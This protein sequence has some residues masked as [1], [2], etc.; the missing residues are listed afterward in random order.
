MA[1]GS[2]V[3]P[4]LNPNTSPNDESDNDDDDNEAF[5]HDIGIVYASL[6]G[7]DNAHA[8]VKHLMET[9]FEHKETIKD[10]NS[11]V[12]EGKWR[13]NLLKQELS[14]NKHTNSFLSQSIKSCELANAKSINDACATNSTTCEASIL[15]E[16]VELRAQLE[17]LTRNYNKLEESHENLSGS[18]GDLLISYNGIKFAHEV[19]ITKKTCCEPHLD[20][21]TTLNQNAILSC[22]SPSNLSRHNISTSCD[23]L[24]AMPCCSNN[25]AS[26]SS[27]TCISTNL[28]EE[29]KEL[30][31]QVTSLEKDLEKRDMSQTY[32]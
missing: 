21:S 28:V 14:E 22:A 4:T 19:P 24:L 8:K 13:F 7:N 5:L 30:K 23:E 1:S 26:T 27:S 32:L 6:R 29:I 18:H 3:T 15:K 12:N 2:N 16:N 11:L 20:I 9:L 17:L 10:L 31:A 25:E